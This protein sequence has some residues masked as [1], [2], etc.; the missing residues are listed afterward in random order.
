MNS[1][2]KFSVLLFII[3]A[4]MPIMTL[5][6][7]S[8]L[9]LPLCLFI[10]YYISLHGIK[11]SIIHKREL[12][13]L[14]LLIAILIIIASSNNFGDIIMR[15][16]EQINCAFVP[17]LLVLYII[18]SNDRL[19]LSKSLFYCLY[20][21]LLITTITTA[22]GNIIY[23]FAS[24]EMATGMGDNVALLRQYYRYNIGGFDFIYTISLMVPIMV[25]V[26]KNH[27]KYRVY[28]LLLLVSSISAIYLSSYTTA[29]LISL[30]G[31]MCV[32]LPAVMTRHSVK[33]YLISI[34][35]VTYL[36]YE[37]LPIILQTLSGFVDNEEIAIRLKDISDMISGIQL[38]ESS[39]IATRQNLYEDSLSGFLE[40][41]ILGIQV[42]RGGH[43]F[44]LCIMCYYGL[45]GIIM[46]YLMLRYIYNVFFKP[47]IRCNMYGHIYI[48][49]V[50]YILVLILNPRTYL[51]L[52]MFCIPLFSYYFSDV[53]YK[54]KM[55]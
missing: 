18:S 46:L 47:F 15:I 3:R 49:Y 6:V 52:P 41:P 17:S 39:D 10:L 32:F 54:T 12:R 2:F 55:A 7:P 4:I 25:Y 51:F 24:R 1:I 34:L 26:A 35:L 9:L 8:F 5:I 43:S 33:K 31:L 19:Q 42:M 16:Y 37:S 40:N 36:C 50:L 30:A 44:I 11:I 23:P 14:F 28:A 38:D 13:Y 29:L 53:I 20:F 48:V 21:V 45:I 27:H 22:V